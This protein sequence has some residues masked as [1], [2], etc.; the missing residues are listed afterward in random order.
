[1]KLIFDNNESNAPLPIVEETP[2]IVEE[3]I[4][5]DYEER[6]IPPYTTAVGFGN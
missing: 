1:M 6:T 4:P 3:N 2:T 5:E